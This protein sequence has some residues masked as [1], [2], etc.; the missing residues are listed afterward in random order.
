MLQNRVVAA[1]SRKTLRNPL[2]SR[3]LAQSPG[4]PGNQL[5]LSSGRGSIDS[6]RA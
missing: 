5:P 1:R 3:G 2:L 4:H 6:L